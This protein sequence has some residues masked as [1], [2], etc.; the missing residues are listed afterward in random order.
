MKKSIHPCLC[1]FISNRRDANNIVVDQEIF[2]SMRG[3]KWAKDWMA[4]KIDL[5]NTYDR[6]QWEFVKETLQDVGYSDI[7]VE[8]V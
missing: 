8:F 4:I 7:F 6:L 1:N 3:K 5:E 2:H